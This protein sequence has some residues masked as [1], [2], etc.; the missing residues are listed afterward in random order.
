VVEHDRP[1]T[2]LNTTIDIFDLSG[3][4]IWSFNQSNADEVSWNLIGNDGIK[5]KS[6]I[7]LYRV[8]INTN[9]SDIESKTNKILIIE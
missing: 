5:V 3:R 7:Y 2:I 4:R 8:S 9:N 1:E 6:G